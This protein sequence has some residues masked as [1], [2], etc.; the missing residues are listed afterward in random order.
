MQSFS[1]RR[2]LA[3]AYGERRCAASVIAACTAG[4]L[5]IVGVLAWL[6]PGEGHQERQRLE[7]RA[8]PA[9]AHR[10][11]VFDQRRDRYEGRSEPRDVAERGTAERAPS[12]LRQ[13][14]RG[15]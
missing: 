10:K 3:E 9:E 15:L 6:A 1:E 5:F 14:K 2:R 12:S 11:Q 7:N 8:R 13:E 4:L